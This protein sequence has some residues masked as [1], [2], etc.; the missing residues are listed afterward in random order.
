[1]LTTKTNFHHSKL[2]KIGHI[3]QLI[4]SYNRWNE[5]RYLRGDKSK[6]RVIAYPLCDNI[7]PYSIGIHTVFAQRLSD[8]KI[9][10][11]SGMY[12]IND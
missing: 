12:L 6:Y 9:I 5:P 1:M 11:V 2:P 10:R 3:G 4:E 8:G 7:L